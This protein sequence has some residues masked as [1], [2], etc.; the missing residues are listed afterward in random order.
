MDRQKAIYGE[1]S[2]NLPGRTSISDGFKYHAPKR[3]IF[4]RHAFLQVIEA[5]TIT[6]H[7]L[8][9]EG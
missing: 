8:F 3:P 4:E 5:L 6:Y 9:V 1:L 2:N 7:M